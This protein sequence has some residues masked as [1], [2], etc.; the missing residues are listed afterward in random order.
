MALHTDSLFLD[1]II[2]SSPDGIISIDSGGIIESFNPASEKLFGYRESEVIGQ[3]IKMLM[4]APYES[5]HDGYIS[6]YLETGEKRI[7]GIGRE[8]FGRRKDGSIFPLELAVGELDIRGEKKFTG[9]I[10]DISRRRDAENE[11][12]LSRDRLHELQGELVHVSR[13]SAMGEMAATL[14]HELNQPLAAMANYAQASRRLLKSS[15]VEEAERIGEL[16]TKAGEQANRAGEII[17]RLR[18]FVAQGETDRSMENLSDVVN[19]GCALALVGAQSEGVDTTLALDAELPDIPMDRIQIQ[20][21]V[22]NLVRN[23]LDA[24][25]GQDNRAITV[26]TSN[27]EENTVQVS[28][29]D[30]GPGI[31]KE[32]A[33]KLFQPFNT[34][35]SDGMGIGLSISRTIIEQHGGAIWATPKEGGGVVFSFT[36]PVKAAMD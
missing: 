29:S 24:T 34:S 8:V 4:P 14:A 20:Q 36:L 17:R 33:E 18:R 10:R 6:R 28:V 7:I 35:K 12:E 11:L 2:E 21:V 31:E 13:L 16:M 9:F 15:E 1:L 5:E 3:N 26:E 22:V 27:G 19:E 32:I 23:S 25:A 30:N